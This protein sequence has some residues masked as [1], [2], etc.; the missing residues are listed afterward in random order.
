MSAPARHFLTGS[1]LCNGISRVCIQLY[2][3]SLGFDGASVCLLLRK[4][5]EN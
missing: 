1:G 2:L 4:E 3:G 5:K